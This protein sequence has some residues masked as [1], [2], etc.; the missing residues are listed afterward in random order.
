M[1]VGSLSVV[2]PSSLGSAFTGLG[3]DRELKLS[4][5]CLLVCGSEQMILLCRG[6]TL[7]CDSTNVKTAKKQGMTTYMYDFFLN[8][9]S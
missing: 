1:I 5:V 7:S 8:L 4:S 6:N 3:S 2:L 9:P